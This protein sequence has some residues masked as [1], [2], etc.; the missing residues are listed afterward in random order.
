MILKATAF[1]LI[2]S[3]LILPGFADQNDWQS[4]DEVNYFDIVQHLGRG[5]FYSQ[6]SDYYAADILNVPFHSN[7]YKLVQD[8]LKKT[9]PRSYDVSEKCL[10]HTEEVMRSLVSQ[11][12]WAVKGKY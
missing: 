12:M 11:E 8:N 1:S 3:A 5:H 9:D 6:K 10:L 2:I 4:Q 7:L